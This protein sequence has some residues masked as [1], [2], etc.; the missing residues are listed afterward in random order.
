MKIRVNKNEY[1]VIILEQS[2]IQSAHTEK[3]ISK[4]SIEFTVYDSAD[5][6][7]MSQ[8][9][10]EKEVL[11]SDSE[12]KKYILLSSSYSSSS[13]D[14]HKS[15]K[16]KL[17]ILE[18][19]TLN[20]EILN[21]DGME[22]IPYFYQESVESE[23]I[24][25]LAK[26]KTDRNGFDFINKRKISAEPVTV[27]RAGISAKPISAMLQAGREWSENNGEYKIIIGMTQRSGRKTNEPL[28][29]VFL[30]LRDY[31]IL[32]RSFSSALM[33]TL[34]KKGILERSESDTVLKQAEENFSRD[35]I[36]F[37][38]VKDID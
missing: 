18:K 26:I 12:L 2:K 38:Q 1:A 13:S 31:S 10:A 33:E 20:A 27:I 17:Q 15:Q 23:E 29:D 8:I 14:S 37:Y 28:A 25:I 32:N 30:K 21:I 6:Q 22:F 35:F 19:E 5:I 11:I 24:Q 7:E 34:V 4:Y 9:I 36:Q 16:Y 3:D